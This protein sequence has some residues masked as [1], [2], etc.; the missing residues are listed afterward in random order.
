[1]PIPILADQPD[2]E[3]RTRLS[4]EAVRQRD[5]DQRVASIGQHH[6]HAGAFADDVGGLFEGTG[7]FDDVARKERQVGGSKRKSSRKAAAPK[8]KS[9]PKKAAAKKTAKK[10]AKKGGGKK[11]KR[12]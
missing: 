4:L 5:P 11:G 10:P 3:Q 12:R 9:S 2:Q 7:A 1:M 6:A 8:K